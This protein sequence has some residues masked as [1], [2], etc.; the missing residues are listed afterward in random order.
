MNSN[1]IIL[2]YAL[3]N[4]YNAN[5]KV[6]SIT[7]PRDGYYLLIAYINGGAVW[8]DGVTNSNSYDFL[9]LDNDSSCAKIIQ[10]NAGDIVSLVNLTGSAC[11]YY[12]SSYLGLI[13]LRG[14][15]TNLNE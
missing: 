4:T 3:V 11:T 13:E 1:L 2:K 14:V 5:A 10:K 7:V 6:I 12:Q 8:L 9:K 15:F